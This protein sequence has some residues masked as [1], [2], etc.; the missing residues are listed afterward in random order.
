MLHGLRTGLAAFLISQV[1]AGPLKCSAGRKG[2]DTHGADDP[3][4]KSA[5]ITLLPADIQL[6]EGGN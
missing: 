4:K 2:Y 6:Y 3:F 1:I 5:W